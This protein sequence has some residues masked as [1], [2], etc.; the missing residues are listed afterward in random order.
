[1]YD[2]R[3]APPRCIAVVDLE[4]TCDDGADR[5][6]QEVIELPCVVVERSTTRVVAA[7]DTFVRPTEAPLLS[8]FCT[9]LTGITQDDVDGA[10]ELPEALEMFDEFVGDACGWG[11]SAFCVATDGAWDVGTMLV[12][13]CARKRVKLRRYW[14]RYFDVRA[15]FSKL[16]YESDLPARSMSAML[17][18]MG[19]SFEGR[20]H[21][22]LDD[23]RNIARVVS[24]I[25]GDDRLSRAA[26]RTTFRTP[27]SFAAPL[28]VAPAPGHGCLWA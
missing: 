21:N 8:P 9:R 26:T 11:S 17:D 7:F 16:Y 13:E 12:G 4:A 20:R 6:P 14:K 23:A 18:E 3:R 10:P 22:G 2:I 24:R 25:L 19:F 27:A 1:M 15:E 28:Y 5:V